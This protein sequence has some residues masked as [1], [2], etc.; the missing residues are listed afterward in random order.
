MEAT[1]LP[2]LHAIE[3]LKHLP[4]TGW[5]RMFDDNP[6]RVE[7]VAAHSFRVA[8]LAMLAPEN[9]NLDVG[10][11]TEMALVH[12]LAESV[13]G[14][15]PTWAKVP[16]E[17][18]YEMEHNGFQYLHNLLQTYSPKTATKISELWLEFEQGETPEAKWVKE[19]DKFEC[20]VQAHEYEQETFG[21]KDFGEFQ[22][23]LK[24]IHS[25][26][27][28]KW[29]ESLSREREDHFAKRQKRLPIIFITG[30]PV[31]CDNIASHVTGELSLPHISM[32]E[33]L[34]E[35]AQDLEY[36]HHGIIKNCLDKRIEVPA[37]LVVEVLENKIK[38]IGEQSWGIVSGFPGDTEQLAEFEKKVQDCNCIL[39][40]E[41]PP[42]TNDQRQESSESEDAKSTWRRPKAPF[43]DVL[44]SSAARFEVVGSTTDQP[45][46]S[47][48]DLCHL[49]VNSIKA[50]ITDGGLVKHGKSAS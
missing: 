39:Y 25:K 4:R 21:K 6:E 18:K 9:L 34:H 48:I 47:E 45:T 5:L 29:A 16:K 17:R 50:F 11:C 15:I 43:K 38:A 46:M 42:H 22:G 40:V 26:E 10:K 24:E 1:P 49:A 44:K 37:S 7:S 27:A 41:C 2:F 32:N 8:I 30:D 36:R 28:K 31:A 33:T 13:I 20:L 23:Q 35:K 3:T 14:D 12:D 19:M